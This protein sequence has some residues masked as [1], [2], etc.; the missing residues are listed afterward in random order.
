M[1]DLTELTAGLWIAA[2]GPYL[3]VM[4]RLEPQFQ[5]LVAA[6]GASGRI[7]PWAQP[8]ALGSHDRRVGFHRARI[9]CWRQ[10]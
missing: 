10:W 1:T 7:A 9:R 4:P 2:G 3:R 6:L 5:R 8:L